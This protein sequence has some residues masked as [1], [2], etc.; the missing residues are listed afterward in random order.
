MENECTTK[1]DLGRGGVVVTQRQRKK[2][3]MSQERKTHRVV[4]GN[5]FITPT[6]RVLYAPTTFYLY[7]L[8]SEA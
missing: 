8:R 6:V 2:N 7:A 5:Y 3:G 1:K 4:R